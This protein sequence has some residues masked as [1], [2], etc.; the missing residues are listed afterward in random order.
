MKTSDFDYDLPP[1][2]I[3]NYPLANKESCNLEIVDRRNNTISHKNFYNITENLNP[4]DVLVLNNT[5]VIPARLY[6]KAQ[7][8]DGIEILLLEKKDSKIWSCL[9]KKPK[10]GLDIVI[11][12][13]IKAQIHK[14]KSGEIILEFNKEI[15]SHIN[16]KGYMPLPPY[17][18]RKPEKSDR[19][20]Y[21]TVYA[22]YEGSVAAPTAGLHFTDSLLQRI[23]DKGVLVEYVTLHVGYGT[24]KPVKSENVEDHNMHS[25]YFE[26]S[27]NT[28][29]AVNNAKEKGSR[30]TAVG[31]T[32]L[33]TLESCVDEDGK[34]Q[35]K[36]GST[37][38][39]IYPGYEFK[40]TDSLITNFHMPRSTLFML[41]CAF[42]G[43]QFMTEA[44][45]EAKKKKYRFLSYGDAMIIV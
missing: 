33:R 31:T 23:R 20:N 43:R 13:D 34:L 19:E 32:S 10:D 2:L 22:E 12:K 18:E 25:E 39:F 5:K 17:I 14:E 1:E 45:E 38:L 42:A 35:P 40:I 30:V 29:K 9:M 6:G 7:N 3:A 26:L 15:D 11:E 16:K 37:D 24:F 8:R 4:G 27:E 36:N 28:C 41:V 21:Q 44:Y